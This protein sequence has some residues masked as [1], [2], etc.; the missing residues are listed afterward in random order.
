MHKPSP[1]STQPKNDRRSKTLRSL[2]VMTVVRGSHET[3][4]SWLT[5]KNSLL[6]TAVPKRSWLLNSGRPRKASRFSL[7]TS[8][9]F[10]FFHNFSGSS[11]DGRMHQMKYQITIVR[12]P[13]RH[14]VKSSCYSVTFNLLLD[15]KIAKWRLYSTILK[16]SLE[17][18][19]LKNFQGRCTNCN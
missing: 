18:M 4:S 9:E 14:L 2:P 12:H 6:E 19:F 15:G 16:T 7:N 13:I 3:G 8:F 17:S 11:T 1:T 5:Q 10:I